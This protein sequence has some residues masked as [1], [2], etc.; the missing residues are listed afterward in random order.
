[1]IISSVQLTTYL[2]VS[3]SLL[4]CMSVCASF[5]LLSIS[6][7]TSKHCTFPSCFLRS[8]QRG[9]ILNPSPGQTK[10]DLETF[11]LNNSKVPLCPPRPNLR[12][13]PQAQPGTKTGPRGLK[14]QLKPQAR[15]ARPLKLKLT[16]GALTLVA[17]LV[18]SAKWH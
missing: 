3:L 13:G 17:G 16:R 15:Q 11:K 6:I 7:L 12:V 5:I 8:A 2:S 4:V 9:A 14:R 18:S 10:C 1:M